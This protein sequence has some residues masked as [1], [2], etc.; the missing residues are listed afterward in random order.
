MGPPTRIERATNGLGISERGIT[1]VFD[2]MGNPLLI[3]AESCINYL[4]LFVSI[5]RSS[6]GSVRLLNTVITPDGGPGGVGLR[7]VSSPWGGY[8]HGTSACG[9]V[10]E[11]AV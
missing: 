2:D 10:K 7:R 5:Y 1:Q 11:A 3:T 6:L 9:S 4:V 8:G